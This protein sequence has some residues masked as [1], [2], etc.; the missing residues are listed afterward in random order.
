[1]SSKGQKKEASKRMENQRKFP[2]FELW[3]S[4]YEIGL[5]HG[6][7]A[8]KQIE[9]SICCYQE[10]FQ[11]FSGISWEE[12]KKYACGM[13]KNIEEYDPEIM[14]EIRGIAE[15]AE[16]ELG[17]ILALNTRSE[18]VLQGGQVGDGCTSVAFTEDVTGDGADWLGQN[19]DWKLEQRDALVV[20]KIHQKDK[21]DLLLFTEAGIVGKFGLN[22]AGIGVCLNALAS[23][24]KV[25]GPA[26]PLHVVLRGILN[27][28][29]LS[30]AI[31]NVGRMNLACCAN[32]HTASAEGQAVAIEAG[33]GDFDVLYGEEGF[34]VH[35]NH[36]LSPRFYQVHDTGK[37]AFPDTF[38]RYGRMR[39]M[40]RAALEG[41]GRIRIETIQSFLRDHKGF[42][43]SI[44]RHEDKN[45]PEG[46]R[47]GTVFSI[48]M[49]LSKREMYL[50]GGNPCETSYELYNL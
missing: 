10:M 21:P 44:C 25:E 29:T 30:D 24:Q 19:W 3:G 31:Q 4:A 22:E 27:S 12:A 37:M 16:K 39:Q 5:A 42:P 14:E 9:A 1:M 48:L 33:P 23:D 15:G 13:A 41:D 17:D 26:V 35:T 11:T 6:R 8:R 40:I 34:L 7:L 43:D 47:M 49:N 20:L 38:L 18:I 46:K 45:D 36:F 50:T 2:V 32:F 28:S